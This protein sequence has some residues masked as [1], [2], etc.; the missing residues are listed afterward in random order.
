MISFPKLYLS[1]VRL[2][3]INSLNF[4]CSAQASAESSIH[5]LVTQYGIIHKHSVIQFYSLSF[6]LLPSSTAPELKELG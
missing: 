1:S 3:L 4:P 5:F 6:W 2:V